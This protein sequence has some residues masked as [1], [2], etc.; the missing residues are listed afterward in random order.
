MLKL[1]YLI[2]LIA[3]ISL[4]II[5]STNINSNIEQLTVSSSTSNEESNEDSNENSNV[6][7]LLNNLNDKYDKVMDEYKVLQENITTNTERIDYMYTKYET[8]NDKLQAELS[9]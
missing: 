8:Q 3:I 4:V 1:L 7:I 2:I 9:S 6:A 5:H